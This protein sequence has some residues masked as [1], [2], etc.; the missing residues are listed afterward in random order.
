MTTAV[1]T[2]RKI[3]LRGHA[4][5][6]DVCAMISA[7]C[8]AMTDYIETVLKETGHF[9]L[10]SGRCDI[11]LEGFSDTAELLIDVFWHSIKGI[12]K[13]YPDNVQAFEM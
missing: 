2:D 10:K 8:V 6:K 12:A 3:T 13:D 7:L 9:K 1:K 5:R 11:D 4:G